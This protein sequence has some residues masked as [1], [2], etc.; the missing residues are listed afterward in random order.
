MLDWKTT[1]DKKWIKSASEMA[2]TIQMTVYA[3][4]ALKV[5]KAERV[6]L[7]HVYFV[8]KTNTPAK[9]VSLV[10]L[11]EQIQKNWEHCEGVARQVVH[12]VAQTSPNEVDA[13]TGACDSYG[14]CPAR[15]VCSA[16]MHDSL[17]SLVGQ[18]AAKAL[19][20]RNAKEPMATAAPSGFLARVLARKVGTAPTPATA[21][22]V[23]EKPALDPKQVEAERLKLLAEERAAQVARL[24]KGFAE[25][26]AKVEHFNEG[27]PKLTGACAAAWGVLKNA[28]VTTVDGSGALAEVNEGLGLSEPEQMMQ[29]AQEL[30]DANEGQP[31]AA[32][33]PAVSNTMGIL[34]ADVPESDPQL[35]SERP[36]DA[37]APAPVSEKKKRRTKA[38]IDADAHQEKITKGLEVVKDTLTS[39]QYNADPQSTSFGRPVATTSAA[40]TFFYVGCIP[41]VPYTRISDVVDDICE[42]MVKQLAPEGVLDI[43][44]ADTGLLAFG[45]WRAV[46][47]A[48]VRETAFAP[49]H[50][51]LDMYGDVAEV[52]AEALRRVAATGAAVLVRAR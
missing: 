52:V 3:M 21:P 25:A 47:T 35:A 39:V 14:G 19:L 8:T 45:K 12:A 24:P 11:P 48:L 37:T 20:Q 22:T 7:S 41:S 38:E 18:T 4:W 27:M 46:L 10:V 15:D 44:E 26:L 23:E 1:S 36:K 30:A 9:K 42:Q 29:L 51:V 5:K 28:K 17:A 49:G 40:D 16:R 6:R 43:R 13:N 34:P 50:H 33:A 31:Q 2:S 32:L